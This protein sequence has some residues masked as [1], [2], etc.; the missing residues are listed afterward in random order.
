MSSKLSGRR[1]ILRDGVLIA[2]KQLFEGAFSFSFSAL[3]H[4]MTIMQHGEHF[5]LRIDNISFS[6][7]HAQEQT[8]NQFVY[9]DAK[10]ELDSDNLQY[11]FQIKNTQDSQPR[12]FDFGAAQSEKVPPSYA[13]RI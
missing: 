9:E 5:E 1:R 13:N 7:I 3:N 2:D 12:T 8:K 4:Q 10:K 11:P 6:H